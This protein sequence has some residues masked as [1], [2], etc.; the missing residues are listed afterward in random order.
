MFVS[1]AVLNVIRAIFIQRTMQVAERDHQLMIAAKTRQMQANQRK[2]E[3]LFHEMDA[4]HSGML[5][6][7][8]LKRALESPEMTRHCK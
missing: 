2:L 5:D 6:I 3:K 1:F 7:V 8:Q 4:D